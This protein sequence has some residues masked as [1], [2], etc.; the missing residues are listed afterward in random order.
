MDAS[1]ILADGKRDLIISFTMERNYFNLTISQL[2]SIVLY[3]L[4]S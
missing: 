4:I 1:T 2:D 3:W